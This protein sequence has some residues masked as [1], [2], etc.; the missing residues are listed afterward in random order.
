MTDLLYPFEPGDTLTA[1]ALNAA[2]AQSSGPAGAPG[3]AGPKG[4]PGKDS[5]VPGPQGPPGAPGANSTVPGPPGPAGAT[6]PPSGAAAGDLAG[7]Y[8]NPTLALT[9]VAPGSYGDGTHVGTFTV[10]TKGRLTAAGSAVITG[11]APSGTAGGD[12]SGTYPAPTLATTTVSPGSYGDGT[13]VPQITVDAKGRITSASNFAIA[14]G[15]GGAPSGA[16]GGDLSGTYPN[17]TLA[18]TAV[19]AGSYTNTNLTVDAKGRIT[20]AANGTAGGGGTG[21][22]TSVGSGAGLSGGPISTTGTLVAQWQAGTVTSLGTGL[23]LTTGVLSASGGGAASLSGLT[24]ATAGNTIASGDNAQV[25]QWKV[26]TN[27]KAAFS[28]AESAASTSTTGSTLVSIGTLAASSL[29]PLTVS[30][31]GLQAIQVSSGGNLVLNG[32]DP[33]TAIQAGTVTLRG[34]NHSGGLPGGNLTIASGSG[35]S[36]GTLAVNTPTVASGN[37]S[38]GTITLQTGDTPAAGAPGNILIKTGTNTAASLWSQPGGDVQV[39]AGNGGLDN[40]RGGDI[41]LTPGTGKGTGRAGIISVPTAAAGTSTTQAASTAF[42]QAAA[43]RYLNTANNTGFSVNQRAYVSGTALA[44]GAF[45]H[46]RWKGGAGG[47]TYT[48]TQSPGPAT[49][50]TIT[51]GTLQQVVEG[52]GLVGGNYM[53]S[54]TGTAQG[55]VGAGSYAASPVSVAG[56]VAGTNTTIEFNAGT[57]GQVKFEAG[58]VATAWVPLLVR[59]ELANCQRFYETGTTKNYGYNSTGNPAGTVYQYKVT[60][61]ATPTL[62]L[63]G[64][65]GA[66]N[67]GATSTL[68][69]SQPDM[70]AAYRAAVA[71][72]QTNFGDTFTASADL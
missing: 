44:A 43:T 54:W 19:A 72:G 16:A 46:D 71:T 49:T 3:P 47:C 8:P 4:D 23:T 7:T 11:A 36:S 25:W 1:A 55:R 70:F 53:L 61:R 65:G 17:P 69:V 18:T 63:T 51:A 22:V 6:S 28:F 21:T 20:A 10:D 68:D 31:L 59:D 29:A 64:S 24:A 42:V 52:A 34:G 40:G 30:A 32:I 2:I 33:T 27:G 35:T 12:L 67:V 41:L 45:G 38:S 5:T 26:T 56:I 48:F 57:L 14:S 60:K 58:T 13:H 39:T 50:V 37:G 66:V 9:G 62:V 15:G